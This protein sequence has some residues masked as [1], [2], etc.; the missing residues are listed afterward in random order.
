MQISVARVAFLSCTIPLSP[1][2]LRAVLAELT[3]N[4]MD[5]SQHR[6]LRN[7]FQYHMSQSGRGFP[8][9]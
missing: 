1:P 5:G 7:G 8:G 9:K 6:V 3:W 4:E 2:L